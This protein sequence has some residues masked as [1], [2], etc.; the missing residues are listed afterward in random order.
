MVVQYANI[1]PASNSESEKYAIGTPLTSNEA[2]LFNMPVP[3]FQDPVCIPYK[4]SILAVVTLALNVNVSS[5]T[6][7]VVMQ[8]DLGDG[9]WIDVAWCVWT[10]KSSSAT[11]A[12]SSNENSSNAVQQTRVAGT[13]PA[14]NGSNAMQLGGRIRFVGAASIGQGSSSSSAGQLS[15]IVSASIR[16]K[17]LGLR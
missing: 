9:N 15:P 16:Y 12:L 13:A 7:Y 8:T 14:A 2:D 6:A 3:P 1:F 4:G 5:N 11:F 17:T 10:G